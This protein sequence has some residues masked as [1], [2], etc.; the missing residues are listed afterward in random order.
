MDFLT[1]EDLEADSEMHKGIVAGWP[2]VL[3]NLKTFLE[4]GRILNI[5][6]GNLKR[7]SQW[8]N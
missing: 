1:H 7:L 4:T 3:S 8:E 6:G 2:R 5:E